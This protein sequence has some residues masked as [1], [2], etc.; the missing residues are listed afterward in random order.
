[1]SVLTSTTLPTVGAP[2]R[3]QKMPFLLQVTTMTWRSLVIVSRNPAEVLPG[4]LISVFF[5]FVQ[6]AS[7]GSGSNF[8]P[9]LAGKS[10]LGFVL[11][12]SIIS[13]ALSGAGIA[14]FS[15]VRDI[16][17]GYFSKLLLTPISRAALLLG[18][19]LAGAL[20]LGLQATTVLLVGL[21]LGLQPA[22]GLLGILA[23]LGVSVLVGTAFAGFTVAIALR[24]GSAGATQGASFIFFP[25]TFLTAS[26]V[27]LSLLTGWL[28]TAATYNPV[29]Y[30]LDAGRSL[31]LDGWN[32]ELLLR[33]VVTCLIM[34][35]VTF[36][37]ALASLRAR[38]KRS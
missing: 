37:F 32:G 25:L 7:L 29:T 38:T 22:T 13:S 21:L 35:A 6:S 14:G 1:M 12:L 31:M 16:E 9:G 2:N 15:I 5:L 36:S 8:I 17:R 20:V 10:Y 11:P 4:I 18:P 28:K 19:I 33:A 23:L 30:I 26:Y 34:G 24:T 27:P 3:D